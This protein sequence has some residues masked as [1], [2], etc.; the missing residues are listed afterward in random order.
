M[1]QFMNVEFAQAVKKKDLPAIEEF[2]RATIAFRNTDDANFALAAMLKDPNVIKILQD[3]PDMH[4]RLLTFAIKVSYPDAVGFLLGEDFANVPLNTKSKDIVKVLIQALANSPDLFDENYQVLQI[5][6]ANE[7]FRT[8]LGTQVKGLLKKVHKDLADKKKLIAIKEQ[9][10]LETVDAQRLRAV[11]AIILEMQKYDDAT[12]L[13]DTDAQKLIKELDSFSSLNLGEFRTPELNTYITTFIAAIKA[14][15]QERVKTF[16]E[17]KNPNLGKLKPVELN[18]LLRVAL[19]FRSNKALR[20]MLETPQFR[21]CVAGPAFSN[22]LLCFAIDTA[23]PSA[24]TAFLEITAVGRRMEETS[25]DILKNLIQA[26]AYMPEVLSKNLIPAICTNP[27]FKKILTEEWQSK[28]DN[29]GILSILKEISKD[30]RG[31]ID[32]DETHLQASANTNP[33]ARIEAVKEIMAF[34][35]SQEHGTNLSTE[36]AR[37]AD[38][39]ASMAQ[40]AALKYNGAAKK[41]AE[42]LSNKQSG[43]GM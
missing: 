43:K 10:G 41:L 29:Q 32:D 36:I 24:A 25:K 37:Q 26:T 38:K 14:D 33:N 2:L 21:D 23:N 28:Q 7:N 31:D 1:P 9:Q 5:V 19:V 17:Q 34:M 6:C 22:R 42:L 39:V 35:D 12:K 18:Q 30:M 13:L 3:H 16:V 27:Q 8:L 4:N 15:D 11:Q 40:H 20:K